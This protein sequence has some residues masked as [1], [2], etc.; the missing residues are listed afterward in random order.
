VR[1]QGLDKGSPLGLHLKVAAQVFL[2]GGMTKEGVEEEGEFFCPDRAFER[3]GWSRR[4]A[5][6][7]QG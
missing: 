1:H 3:E 2:A 6:S 5:F 7:R 4:A